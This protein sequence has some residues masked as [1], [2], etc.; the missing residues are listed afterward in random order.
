MGLNI[1]SVPEQAAIDVNLTL[2]GGKFLATKVINQTWQ[3]REMCI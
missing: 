1:M 2:P 3:R